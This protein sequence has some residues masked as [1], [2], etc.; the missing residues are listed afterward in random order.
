MHKICTKTFPTGKKSTVH[1]LY[2]YLKMRDIYFRKQYLLNPWTDLDVIYIFGICA[3]RR[4]IWVLLGICT[5]IRLKARMPLKI[6]KGYKKL[7][8]FLY[9]FLAGSCTDPQWYSNETS[10]SSNSKYIKTVDVGKGVQV[11]PPFKNMQFSLK[12]MKKCK[13]TY[14]WDF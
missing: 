4:I 5:A 2:A 9:S 1:F 12:I 13:K 8:F 14:F 7:I 11:Q 10:W 6:V 3:A